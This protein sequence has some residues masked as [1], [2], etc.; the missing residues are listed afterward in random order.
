MGIKSRSGNENGETNANQ[1]KPIETEQMNN[2]TYKIRQQNKHASIDYSKIQIKYEKS[3]TQI[4]P[5]LS[6]N[7]DHALKIGKPAE[8]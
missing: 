6:S 1:V 2:N 3:R 7:L 5:R 4:E 8:T